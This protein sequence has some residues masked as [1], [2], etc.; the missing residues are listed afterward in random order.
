MP[1]FLKGLRK[2]GWPLSVK[3]SVKRRLQP[4]F[5]TISQN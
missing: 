1:L 3:V 5:A 4:Q 2:E